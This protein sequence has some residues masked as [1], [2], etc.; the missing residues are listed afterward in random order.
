ME[1]MRRISDSRLTRWRRR[2]FRESRTSSRPH[3]QMLTRS[4]RREVVEQVLRRMETQLHES[5]G[6]VLPRRAEIDAWF[7]G[8]RVEDI[9]AA[10]KDAAKGHEGGMAVELLEAIEAGLTSLKV[11]LAMLRLA[12]RAEPPPSLNSCLRMELCA[13]AVLG[14]G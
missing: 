12:R 13:V 3:W 14:E 4:T 9:V 5:P 10:L 8:D 7:V 6:D 1:E 2:I 11:T